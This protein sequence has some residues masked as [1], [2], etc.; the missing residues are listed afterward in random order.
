M[1]PE[2]QLWPPRCLPETERSGHDECGTDHTQ[3]ERSTLWN[4]RVNAQPGND[5]ISMLAHSEA[6]RNMSAEEYLGNILLLIVGGNDTTRNSMTGGLL[7]L[8]QNAGEYEKLSANPALI[9]TMIPEIIRWQTPLI[10]MR[11]TALQDI[12]F[13]GKSIKQGDKVV[14]WYLSGNRDPEAIED[15]DDFIIDRT[16]PRQHLS[17]GFGI[18]RCVGNRLAEL[19]L[20]ILWEELLKRWPNPMQ[21][22]VRGEPVRVLS[23]FVRGYESLPVRING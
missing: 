2:G 22:E 3:A 15:A 5:L 4:Q 17:F 13:G 8:N 14:M 6:T 9:P 11:R 1:A 23:P 20:R 21:I 19:Q 16:R 12:E 7:A 10:H 18:H